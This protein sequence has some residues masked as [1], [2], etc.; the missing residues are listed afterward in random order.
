MLLQALG[1]E[2]DEALAR[3]LLGRGIERPVLLAAQAAAVAPRVAGQVLEAVVADEG[4]ALEV[5]VDV[6]R[7]GFRQ[8][9]QAARAARWAAPRP[10]A[11]AGSAPASRSLALVAQAREGRRVPRA[12]SGGE[13]SVARGDRGEGRDALA[14]ELA[15]VRGADVR[16]ERGMVVAAALVVAVLPVVAD[17]A[18]GDGVRIGFRKWGSRL[19]GGDALSGG[20]TLCAGVTADEPRA[21]QP[22]VGGEVGGAVGP[23]PSAADDVEAQRRLGAL[24]GGEHL[25]VGAELEDGARAVSRASLV[26]T[27]S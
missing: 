20:D 7:R 13:L 11:A 12:G 24:H 25:A 19:R 1:H 23:P 8:A 5:E 27:G 16:D 4:V 15:G 14:L 21:D 9:L 17:V 3:G 18:V 10:A 26:S 2:V 6:S 22:E